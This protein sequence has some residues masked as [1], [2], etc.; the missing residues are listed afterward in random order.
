MRVTFPDGEDVIQDL[1]HGDP[2]IPC[3]GLAV[4]VVQVDA[5]HE[6]AVDVEL[7]VEG[8]AVA[9]ANG[10]AASVSREMAAKVLI[11]A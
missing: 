2:L 6:L 5:V 11:F 4:L 10:G 8:G 9:D 7:L 3:H 1:A